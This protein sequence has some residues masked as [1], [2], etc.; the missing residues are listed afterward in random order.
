MVKRETHPISASFEETLDSL[1]LPICCPLSS[2]AIISSAIIKKNSR[3]FHKFAEGK[4]CTNREPS[5][6]RHREEKDYSDGKW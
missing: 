1:L 4:T 3:V 6:F 5:A 2:S